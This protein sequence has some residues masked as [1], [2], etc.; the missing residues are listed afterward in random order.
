M[1]VGV[2]V[3]IFYAKHKPQYK[4]T[5]TLIYERIGYKKM[6]NLFIA[7][8]KAHGKAPNPKTKVFIENEKNLALFKKTVKQLMKEQFEKN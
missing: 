3:R 4:H 1:I 7:Y 6:N 5:Y 8:E 2:M